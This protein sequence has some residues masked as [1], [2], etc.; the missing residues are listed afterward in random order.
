[1][2][3]H[4]VFHAGEVA[5][6]LRAG[7]RAIAER[8][9]SLVRDRLIDA[10][11]DFVAR[12][13]V[14]A[15]G[16]AASDGSLW[17]SLWCGTAGFLHTNETGDA[18]EICYDLADNIADPVRPIIRSNAP[19]GLLV[20][21]LEERR[22]LRINGI[23]GR[24]SDST[25][26]LRIEE[27]F[28]NCNKYIQKR[29]RED[30]A[31]IALD[32]GDGVERGTTLDHD[33]LRLIS[34]CDTLFVTSVHPERGIDTSHRGGLPGFAR[35]TSDGALRIPDYAGNSMFQTLGNLEADPRAG[36]ALIDFER[37][38]VLS[39]TGHALSHFGDEDPAH[40]TGGTGRYWTFSVDR[41]VEFP[42][43]RTMRWTLVE[44]SPF[45]PR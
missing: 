38:R 33:R 3:A 30:V 28:G 16:A 34:R 23:V 17:A 39:A 26:E 27:A 1:M 31:P 18:L 7:E 9:A 13:D 21:D 12:Q 5:V 45:N 22:R 11:R 6:Q 44:Q 40:P 42:L 15:A 32:S 14:V 36:V 19:L 41:W 37:R 24:A 29:V 4:D 25:I 10:A 2:T 43:P 8:R 20:I 35:V